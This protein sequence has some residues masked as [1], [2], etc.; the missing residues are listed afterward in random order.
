M[1]NRHKHRLEQIWFLSPAVVK[2]YYK[3]M[4]LQGHQWKHKHLFFFLH[5]IGLIRHLNWLKQADSFLP[6]FFNPS[7]FTRLAGKWCSTEG[8]PICKCKL[9][10]SVP[11][12]TLPSTTTSAIDTTQW[13][14]QW[15]YSWKHFTVPHRT[16][17]TLWEGPQFLAGRDS[18]SGA[19]FS[20]RAI[21]TSWVWFAFPLVITCLD[22]TDAFTLDETHGSCAKQKED[23][24]PRSMLFPSAIY[25]FYRQ[26]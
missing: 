6:V 1:E 9:F 13:H 4:Y 26:V 22:D 10:C 21:F 5:K 18:K 20:P 24:L 19:I 16:S 11:S 25:S 17:P 8:K 15:C 23:T 14:F 7:N 2:Q 3:Q 12:L